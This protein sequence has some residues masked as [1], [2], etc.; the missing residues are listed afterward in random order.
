MLEEHRRSAIGCLGSTSTHVQYVPL[1]RNFLS[2][3]GGRAG[4]HDNE[5]SV[6]SSCEGVCLG[7]QRRMFSD[8]VWVGVWLAGL[9]MERWGYREVCIVAGAK[10]RSSHAEAG[11]VGQQVNQGGET[12][13][14]HGVGG[15]FGYLGC[16]SG[17]WGAPC[18]M[19]GRWGFL[20]C[21]V[22]CEGIAGMQIGVLRRMGRDVRGREASGGIFAAGDLILS[23]F[24]GGP[25]DWDVEG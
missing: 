13:V 19:S 10:D 22:C 24:T 17:V 25:G 4:D 15:V 9:G 21:W 8:G 6:C 23:C 18:R 1:L 5:C 2:R 20:P 7:S 16:E 3:K 14:L 11:G 12:P